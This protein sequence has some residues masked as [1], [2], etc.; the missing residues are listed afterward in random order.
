MKFEL[1]VSATIGMDSIAGKP[2]LYICMTAQGDDEQMSIE[3]P[4]LDLE[5]VLLNYIESEGLKNAWMHSEDS[6]IEL[7]LAEKIEEFGRR[8]KIAVMAHREDHVVS[9]TAGCIAKIL[10]LNWRW[11]K[12]LK[13]LAVDTKLL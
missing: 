6:E 3:V 11:L 12:K 5:E 9:E 2:K 8:Y 1:D 7:A 13:N 4:P 10:K